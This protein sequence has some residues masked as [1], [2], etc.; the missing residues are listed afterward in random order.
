MLEA[1]N[2]FLLKQRSWLV[3][4]DN[5]H[6]SITLKVVRLLSFHLAMLRCVVSVPQELR[7]RRY[8]PRGGGHIIATGEKVRVATLQ[9][10]FLILR[11]G[12]GQATLEDRV[13]VGPLPPPVANELIVSPAEVTQAEVSEFHASQS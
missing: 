8:F 4:L 7:Q 6:P 13:F 12:C 10:S 1:V 5:C 3:V 2:A 9:A 11:I